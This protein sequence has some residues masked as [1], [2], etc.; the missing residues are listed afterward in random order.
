VE[1]SRHGQREI[2]A[3]RSASPR[4]DARPDDNLE[5]A[6]G[7][8]R[9]NNTTAASFQR[10]IV[11]GGQARRGLGMAA[12]NVASLAI[13]DCQFVHN[14]IAVDGSVVGVLEQGG[15]LLGGGLFL[16]DCGEAK[17]VSSLFQDNSLT[18]SPWIGGDIGTVMGGGGMFSQNTQFLDVQSSVFSSNQL[19]LLDGATGT[20]SQQLLGGGVCVRVADSDR[21]SLVM[22]SSLIKGNLLLSSS[23]SEHSWSHVSL[24]GPI[25]ER[26]Q[27]TL[28]P[29]YSAAR[30]TAVAH[31]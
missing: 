1:D 2:D 31:M 24:V 22:A 4:Q 14:S 29:F 7:C 17:I 26:G 16:S 21:N 19:H 25:T 8:V 3:Q 20:T 15:G 5:D 23:S 11:E 13:S 6:G 9:V 27:C 12:V 10:I 18:A 30:C 28:T